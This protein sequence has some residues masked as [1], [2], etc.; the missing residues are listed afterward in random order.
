VRNTHHFEVLFTS[1]ATKE[2]QV[3]TA[4][5]ARHK[6]GVLFVSSLYFLFGIFGFKLPANMV[7]GKVVPVLH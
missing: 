6:E 1:N 4:K 5:V 2:H 3:M 7:K